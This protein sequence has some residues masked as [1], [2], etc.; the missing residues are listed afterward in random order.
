MAT[1]YY[2]RIDSAIKR[3]GRFDERLLLSL[4]DTERRKWFLWDFVERRLKG[5]T[6]KHLTTDEN[7]KKAFARVRELVGLLSDTVL[8]GYGDLKALVK[9]I[10]IAQDD[11]W[12]KI[13]KH[14]RAKR[15]DVQPSVKLGAYRSRL[16]GPKE[17]KA[18]EEFG[19]LLYLLGEAGQRI[20][21]DLTDIVQ[22]GY[23]KS[24]P[25]TI[26]ECLLAP[27]KAK[28]AATKA[29]GTA[30]APSTRRRAGERKAAALLR[31][32]PNRRQTKTSLK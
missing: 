9:L 6:F 11:T 29:I 4:P 32:L 23:E 8:F 31:T 25:A 24:D 17:E 15:M 18:T 7:G 14:L 5:K 19:I 12:S 10:T 28:V 2:E 26:A 13:M 21:S 27:P 3:Q 1:N 30:L 20:E 16:K 22:D